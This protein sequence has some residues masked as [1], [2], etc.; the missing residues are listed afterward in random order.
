MA[1]RNVLIVAYHYPPIRSAGV[2]RTAK[3]ERYLPEFGYRT[4]ILTTAAFGGRGDARHLRAW[5]PL[6]AYRWLFNRQARQRPESSTQVRTAAGARGQGARD[7]VNRWLLVPDGQITWAPAAI[8]KGLRL[9]RGE[10][11]DLIYSTSPPASGHLIALMLAQ[12]TGLPWVADFRDSW[13]YDP[14]DPALS[15]D[16][17]RFELEAWLEAAVVNGADAT[18]AATAVSADMLRQQ[19]PAARDRIS[20]ITNGFDPQD[21]EVAVD[22]PLPES[23]LFDTETPIEA[24]AQQVEVPERGDGEERPM[25]VV[26]TGSFAHSHPS[27][28][29]AGLFGALRLLIAEN[30]GWMRKLQVILV[31]RLTRDELSSAADLIEAGIVVIAGEVDA[32]SARRFQRDADLLLVVDHDRPWPASNVPGKF[33]D[34]LGVGH[35]I[36]ALCGAG[37]LR[38]LMEELGGGVWVRP[39]EA[40]G[41][42]RVLGE[43]HA[44]FASGPLGEDERGDLSRFHRRELSG[45]LAVRFDRALE[46]RQRPFIGAQ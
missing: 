32:A 23:L 20:V 8:I 29:P 9:L 41:I 31:G 30:D 26:H 6:A 28:S 16:S 15:P 43:F 38:D 12:L 33:Y 44:R 1:T 2:E 4:T 42:A 27:R 35:P 46:R 45:E 24:A 39:D 25:R 10:P 3:F 21:L 34:Y 14:L 19:H 5:E 11:V 22:G 7:F 17:S 37:A 36:L 40:A 18:I 13:V